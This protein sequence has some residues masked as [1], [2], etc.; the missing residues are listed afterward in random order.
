MVERFL[1]TLAAAGLFFSN[2]TLM[3]RR[4]KAKKKTRKRTRRGIWRFGC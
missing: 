4:K 1:L 2:L 3:A